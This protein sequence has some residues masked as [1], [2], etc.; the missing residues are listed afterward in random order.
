MSGV[1]LLSELNMSESEWRVVV[2]VL[3]RWET[4]NS[5]NLM[6]IDFVLVDENVSLVHG[7]LLV[8]Y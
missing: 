8:G 6:W 3:K 1:S 2:K 7:Q 4:T 5:S